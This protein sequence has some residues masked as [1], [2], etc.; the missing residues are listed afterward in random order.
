MA[1]QIR[2]LMFGYMVVQG[3]ITPNPIE[4][5]EVKQIYISYLAGESYK[6]IADHLT[7]RKV[8][9][10]PTKCDWNKNRVKRLLENPKYLGSPALPQ[11]IDEEVYVNVQALIS[12]KN[13]GQSTPSKETILLRNHIKCAECGRNLKKYLTHKKSV[14]KCDC[15]ISITEKKLEE[16]TI[17]LLEH[18]IVH[19]R[20]CTNGNE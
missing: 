13:Q 6:G 8:E 11:I 5:E 15:K 20:V 14:W 1:K 9:Y 10:L 19:A 12:S 18:I 17:K 16:E 7:Q 4:V 3:E 2:S